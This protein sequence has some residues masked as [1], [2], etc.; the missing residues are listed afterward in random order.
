MFALEW[1]AVNL[2][3]GVLT[4]RKALEEINGKV[5]VKVPKTRHSRRTVTL[6]PIAIKALQNRLEKAKAEGFDPADVPI[7]FPDTIG[8]YLR[9]SNFDRYIWYPIRKA[10]GVSKSVTFHDLRHTQASLMLHAGVDMKVIQRRL[11]HADYGTTA[12]I[13]AHLLQDAQATASGMLGSLM[14]KTAPVGTHGGY[15][16][17][18]HSI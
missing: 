11:G 7:C 3:E 12:N 13:Y 16:K 1:N 15:K 10:A 18:A 6:E 14:E 2:R 17:N 4:V 8:G 9:G 5:I